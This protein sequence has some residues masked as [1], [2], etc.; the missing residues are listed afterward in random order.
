M[1]IE[2]VEQPWRRLQELAGRHLGIV[3]V[4]FL[5]K[6]AAKL[7]PLQ[8]GSVLVTR[9]NITAVRQGLVDPREVFKLIRCGVNVY[10]CAN[11]HAKVYV[12]GARAVVGSANVS[13]TSAQGMIEA[14]YE[15][16]D[17]TAVA[18]ARAFVMRHASAAI[19]DTAVKK[20]FDAY[21]GERIGG[22]G[23]G[24]RE[25][26]AA[27]PRMWVLPTS[28]IDLNEL[29]VI[30]DQMGRTIARPKLT[31]GRAW[32]L[33]RFDWRGPG[34][35]RVKEHDLLV[36]RWGAS[37]R[38]QF[39]APARVLHIEPYRGGAVLQLE[40]R[41]RLAQRATTEVRRRMG[42]DA[43]AF[44]FS[45]ESGRMVRD[46]TAVNAFEKLWAPR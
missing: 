4:P 32:S 22:F 7:L 26:P 30:A 12:F 41:P 46:P 37:R 11:L 8:E 23:G 35:K 28:D 20:M 18:S 13:T 5:G 10:D 43:E 9:M 34:W 1:G 2:F 27:L 21:P 44:L 29:A 25:P 6:A 14:C 33:D 15:T 42:A 39:D 40:C 16:T 3:A 19:G 38:Y 24:E 45:G 17:K 36:C 31:E